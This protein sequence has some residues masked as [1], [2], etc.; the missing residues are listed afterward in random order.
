MSGEIGGG[1][2]EALR[3][4]GVERDKRVDDGGHVVTGHG[5]DGDERGKF[6]VAAGVADERAQVISK[7]LHAGLVDPDTCNRAAQAGLSA[8]KYLQAN[9]SW[10]LLRAT[11]DLIV[12][13]PTYTNL[14]D[15]QILLVR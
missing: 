4:N 12:T 3:G 2:G 14:M 10:N 6:H 11:G 7:P 1:F 5:V 13:G 15:L 8:G 9:D